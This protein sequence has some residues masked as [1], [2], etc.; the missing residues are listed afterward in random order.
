MTIRKILPR[1]ATGSAS[2]ADPAGNHARSTPRQARRA[3]GL[4]AVLACLTAVGPLAIDMYI[5]GFPAMSRALHT[6]SPA[7]QPTLTAFPVGVVVGQIVIGPS[8]TT[9]AGG[10]R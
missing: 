3:R 9:S 7:I 5:P 2:V 8:A 4:L 10:G 6:S 1:G